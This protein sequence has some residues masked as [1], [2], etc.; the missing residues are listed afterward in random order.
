MIDLRK[1]R[2]KASDISEGSRE[3][4]NKGTIIVGNKCLSHARSSTDVIL[5]HL[6]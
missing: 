3:N 1:W 6:P 5:D 2:Q 4:D